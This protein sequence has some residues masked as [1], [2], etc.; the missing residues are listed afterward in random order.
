[1]DEYGGFAGYFHARQ[2]WFYGLLAAIFLFDIADTALK[3]AAH[4]HAFG[5]GYP[6]VL[7]ALAVVALAATRIR[8]RRFHAGF[9]VAMLALEA[10]W[11][12]RQFDVL[13]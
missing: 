13:G 10:W 3:G 9:V 4:L 2:T 7:G 12:L 5:P 8:D 11:I 6:V 1:M